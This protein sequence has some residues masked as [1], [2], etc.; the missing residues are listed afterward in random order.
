MIAVDRQSLIRA[1][2]TVQ[3]AVAKTS[4]VPSLYGIRLHT[5]GGM[6]RL[7]ASNL[8]STISTTV[9]YDGDP[10]D[11]VASASTLGRLLGAARAPFVEL[12]HA[13]GSLHVRSGIDATMPT[14]ADA[15][16]QIGDQVIGDS[17]V[18]T[19][20]DMERIGR[21]VH[22]A[23]LDMGRPSLTAVHLAG[24]WAEATDS[25]RLARC[26]LE[27]DVP[28]VSIPMPVLRFVI[29]GAE[30]P[31]TFTTD[32]K[33]ASFSSG[34]T[35][36]TTSLIPEE[37]RDVAPFVEGARRD[38]TSTVVAADLVDLLGAVLSLGTLDASSPA[39]IRADDG[40]MS[41]R[42][43]VR[44]VGEITDTVDAS[45][46]MDEIAVRPDFLVDAVTAAQVDFVEIHSAGPLRPL[47]VESPGFVALVMPV[48]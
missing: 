8:D 43:S 39:V 4:N 21:V 27:V 26:A 32:G 5:D 40:V 13:V 33:R 18:F 31:V 17:V 25:Y 20:E 37:F 48:R 41:A 2:K 22:A 19:A 46:G 12:E 1:A 14:I 3:P 16:P 15:W 7:T 6:L 11:V 36:W 9:E 44:G 47:V 35:T 23:S 45:G 42:R 29:D 34:P 38:K 10:F 30:S 28:D 24:R